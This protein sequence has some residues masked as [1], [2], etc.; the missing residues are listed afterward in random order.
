M[1]LI[2]GFGATG[3][4]FLRYTRQNNIPV[5]ILDTRDSPPGLTEFEDLNE[6]IHLGDFDLSTFPNIDKI[7]VS[8]GVDYKAPIL[9]EAKN[10][11]IKIQT[12]IELFVED[13]SSLKFLVTG[14]NGKTSVVS[15]TKHVLSKLFPKNKIIYCGN[16]GN[17]ALD[18]INERN[19]LSIV[20]VSSFHLEHSANI[21][22]DLGVLLNIDQDH[23]DIH[24]NEEAYRRSK[25]KVLCNCSIGLSG[26]DEFLTKEL[27]KKEN[28]YFLKNL[29]RF[30]E[31]ISSFLE[32]GWPLHEK[33][34]IKAVLGIVLAYASIK[35]KKNY[36]DLINKDSDLVN[37]A[38]NA[39]LSF[40]RLSHRFERLGIKRG[41]TYINDSKSTNI[42]SLLTAIN[43]CHHLYG[44]KRTI[45]ICGG[46]VKG[47]D[48]SNIDYSKSFP[49]KQAIVFG[50]DKKIL[51]KALKKLGKSVLAEDLRDSINI[52]QSIAKKGDV[53]LLS[54]GC[55]SLDMFSNYEDRGRKFIEFSGFN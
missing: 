41:V 49:I 52:S 17:P 3:A 31:Q 44:A 18:F 10:K 40:N 27:S 53:I 15:M 7:L 48:F 2:L 37:R 30:E 16:I 39:L 4:S 9:V 12:D 54:P 42:S 45:L 38:L 21:R 29:D 14:T 35:N 23:L 5:T 6:E 22:G 24:L 36:S 25:E 19:D 20:E 32:C 11:G 47:Q 34:N 51:E 46:E 13:S 50:R 8:P 33:D 43:S 1:H 26:V 28:I 55:S